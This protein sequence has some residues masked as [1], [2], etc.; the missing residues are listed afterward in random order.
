MSEK[1]TFSL[2]QVTQII[3]ERVNQMFPSAFWVR[4]EMNKLNHNAFSGHAYPELVEKSNGKVISEMRATF[5]RS[6]F[7]R[8]NEQFEESVGQPLHDG[9]NVLLY[10]KISFSPIYGLSLNILDVDPSYTLGELEREKQATINKLKEE[11]IF[12]ANKN[13]EP[14]LL[15]QRLAVITA[16]GSKGYSDF[17]SVLETNPAGYSFYL[18]VFPAVM[19]GDASPPSILKQLKLVKKVLPHFDAVVIIRG[20]GGEVGMTCYNDYNLSREVATFPIPVYSGI[21][22]STNLTV[23][24][25]VSHRHG[26]TPTQTAQYFIDHL[27]EIEQPLIQAFNVIKT[28]VPNILEES[29][30][31]IAIA[32]KEI[33][34]I[35]RMRVSTLV[36]NQITC[37]FRLKEVVGDY[38]TRES[39]SHQN[40]ANQLLQSSTKLINK[41]ET[42][43][44]RASQNLSF[45]SKSV[46]KDKH[47][48][49]EG[50]ESS[51]RLLDPQNLL[52]RGYS[53]T[54]LNGEIVRSSDEV[55]K[56]DELTTRTAKGAIQSIVK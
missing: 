19:Q 9:I 24:E 35:T 10:V 52:K 3:E 21:G 23:V 54:S 11:K 1:R 14:P 18:H 50:V 20:G 43:L 48:D 28:E 8:S 25:Q 29:K 6:V 44:L 31:R 42:S 45:I 32:A 46:L 53:I 4:A 16:E 38:V 12:D 51:L 17:K 27:E 13:I 7:Q 47:R 49:M 30:A 15:M 39:K 36:Q 22:H 55:K 40:W 56:G 2:S 5:F 26:I 33:R 37:R 34:S 41:Q